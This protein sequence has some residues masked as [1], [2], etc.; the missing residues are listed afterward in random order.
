M[1]FAAACALRGCLDHIYLVTAMNF[2]QFDILAYT[3]GCTILVES[4]STHVLAFTHTRSRPIETNRAQ[5]HLVGQSPV[6]V[7]S[8]PLATTRD[9]F[10][11]LMLI[12][13]DS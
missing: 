13:Y 7:L 9:P 4:C 1:N 10:A 5:R 3:V 2:F 11:C 8:S 6:V 12:T